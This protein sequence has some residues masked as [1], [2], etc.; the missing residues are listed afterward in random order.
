M[1]EEN[2]TIALYRACFPEVARVIKK[3]G[4]TLEEAKDAFHDALLIYLER[5][6]KGQDFIRTSAQAYLIGTARIRW[7]QTRRRP[8]FVELPGDWTEGELL[9][10]DA[11]AEETPS[12]WQLVRMGGA[13]CMRLLSA[14]YFENA[15]M[16]SLA[17]R[18]GFRNRRSATVQKYKCLEKIRSQLKQPKS[19]A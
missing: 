12:L 11:T 1:N 18:F 9:Q 17:G 7:L 14:F 2:H 15:T 8:Q 5:S 4:G 13:R 10:T 16:D 19:Y 3:L 6:E